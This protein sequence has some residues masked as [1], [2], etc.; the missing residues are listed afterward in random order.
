MPY[1]LADNNAPLPLIRT[2]PTHLLSYLRALQV[3]QP[4]GKTKPSYTRQASA[5]DE[6]SEANGLET[7]HTCG[8]EYKYNENVGVFFWRGGAR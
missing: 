2:M 3:K 6:R 1:Y 7:I 4:C 5:V 8:M